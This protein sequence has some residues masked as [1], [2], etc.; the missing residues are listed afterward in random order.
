MLLKKIAILVLMIALIVNI[1]GMYFIIESVRFSVKKEI[2]RKIKL[3]VPENELHQLKFLKTDIESGNAEL[4][5]LEDNEFSFQGKMYDV[6]RTLDDGPYIIYY[7][8]NDF[9]EEQLFA[10]LDNMIC[11]QLTENGQAKAKSRLLQ[12]LLIHEAVADIC[13][14]IPLDHHF[15]TIG[16][17]PLF[18]IQEVIIDIPT[19]PP[20]FAI[21]LSI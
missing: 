13:K 2:K 8:I 3:G 1:C 7:C 14:K 9:Q 5:W 11:K 15:T 4:K 16:T 6:V 20:Q 12:R 10:S 18:S 19:P 21:L 17:K